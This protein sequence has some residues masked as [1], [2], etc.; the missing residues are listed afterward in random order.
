LSLEPARSWRR[1]VE[2]I[3]RQTQVIQ[4]ITAELVEHESGWIGTARQ[5]RHCPFTF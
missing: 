5:H 2:P 1:Q 3:L 4:L